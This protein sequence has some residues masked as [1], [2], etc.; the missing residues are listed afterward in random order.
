MTRL[1]CCDQSHWIKPLHIKDVQSNKIILSLDAKYDEQ[2]IQFIEKMY[3]FYI[4]LIFIQS[5]RKKIRYRFELEKEGKTTRN[6]CC[7]ARHDNNLNPLY[8]FSVRN[9]RQHVWHAASIAVAEAPA[10]AYNPLFL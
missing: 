7:T 2:G 4:S 9:Q 5:D 3:D 8:T 10:E 1:Q 6:S